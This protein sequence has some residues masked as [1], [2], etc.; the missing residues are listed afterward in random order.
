[1]V[2]PFFPDPPDRAVHHAQSVER[3]EIIAGLAARS[4]GRPVDEIM[5]ELQELLTGA[6]HSLMPKPWLRAVACDAAEGKLFV[7]GKRAGDDASVERPEPH[8]YGIT[9]K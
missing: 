9:R 2:E 1:M 5:V 4:K 3:Q 7:V 8:P 6:G